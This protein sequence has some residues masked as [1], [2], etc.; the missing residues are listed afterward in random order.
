MLPVK[1]QLFEVD[2]ILLTT[3]SIS[4]HPAHQVAPLHYRL[5]FLS[6]VEKE[7]DLN[8]LNLTVTNAG[9]NGSYIFTSNFE[10]TR[11]GP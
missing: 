10:I 9:G 1:R 3:N 11:V 7:A 4:D 8:Q 6:G 5:L 2:N